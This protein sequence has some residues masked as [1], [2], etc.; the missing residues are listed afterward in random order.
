MTTT[1]DLEQ[2]ERDAR[3]DLCDECKDI[4]HPTCSLDPFCICC[5]GTIEQM[6]LDT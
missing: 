1:D 6:A 5:Q 4:E 2:A 3:T